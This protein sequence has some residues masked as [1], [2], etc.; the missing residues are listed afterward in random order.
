MQFIGIV[1]GM[2]G[3]GLCACLLI[4]CLFENKENK[5]TKNKSHTV[6]KEPRDEKNIKVEDSKIEPPNKSL[7]RVN[8]SKQS[9]LRN[10][11][12]DE[13]FI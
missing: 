6:K 9:S 13:P 11:N 10:D 2:V 4:Y 3:L 1:V 12:M 5:T 7:K 8:V